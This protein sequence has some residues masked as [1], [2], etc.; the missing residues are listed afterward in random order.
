MSL[1]GCL[2]F[3]FG[4]HAKAFFPGDST[5]EDGSF[6][7]PGLI[8]PFA[9]TAITDVGSEMLQGTCP[10]RSRAVVYLPSLKLL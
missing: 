9:K 7:S 3:L 2:G 8:G 1:T 5:G 6:W 10:P 4:G